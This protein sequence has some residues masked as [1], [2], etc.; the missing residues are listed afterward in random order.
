MGSV[1]DGSNP[2]S[3]G[4]GVGWIADHWGWTGVFVTMSPAAS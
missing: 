3:R 1:S 4:T 2:K